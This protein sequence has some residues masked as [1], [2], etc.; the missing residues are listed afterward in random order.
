MAVRIKN[1]WEVTQRRG[2]DVKKIIITRGGPKIR[3]ILNKR[4]FNIRIITNGRTIKI[5]NLRNKIK[6]RTKA[7]LI[8][9]VS[10]IS[11]AIPN[12]EE[13]SSLGP[14]QRIETLEGGRFR[15]LK[16]HGKPRNRKY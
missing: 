2:K 16:D 1:S 4:I 14:F 13:M 7:N 3:I 5:S 9:K 12:L 11:I 8:M 10:S 15:D 6:M